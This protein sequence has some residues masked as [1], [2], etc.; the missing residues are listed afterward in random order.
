MY[1]GQLNGFPTEVVEKMLERQVEQGNKKDVTAFEKCNVINFIW[2]KTIEG[3]QF[4]E[5]VIINK[6]FDVFFNKYPKQIEL[7][8]CFAI[9]QN[10]ENP[11]WKQYIDFLN[12]KYKNNLDG[13]LYE[14]YGVNN[15][16]ALSIHFTVER[17][18]KDVVLLTLEQW[19]DLFIKPTIETDNMKT[20]F[21]K[22]FI[23]NRKDNQQSLLWSTFIN[24]MNIKFKE[25]KGTS[26]FTGTMDEYYGFDSTYESRNCIDSFLNNP[27]VVT[28][29]EWYDNIYKTNKMEKEIIGYIVPYD[30]NMYIKKDDL[31]T[32]HT[33]KQYCKKENRGNGSEYY[34]YEEL[35]KTW[36]PVYKTEEVIYTMG[37]SVTGTFQLVVK[38]GKCFHKSEDITNYVKGV[39]EFVEKLP[40]KISNYDFILDVENITIKK[41]GCENCSTTVKDWLNLKPLIK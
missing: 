40:N 37:K 33:S 20:E 21:P 10:R 34:L 11:L 12:K 9:K 35:V 30:I 39:I 25:A 27:Q 24:W 38:D 22:Y 14:Y 36:Q 19:Y 17:F 2:S 26:P 32:K 23:L 28:I 31:F 5:K 4:W 7:P 6:K 13:S 8:K 3:Q 29:K 18:G 1:K 15:N 16:N 41:S